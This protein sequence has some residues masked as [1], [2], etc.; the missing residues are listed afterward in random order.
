[1]QKEF[2]IM[3]D[4]CTEYEVDPSHSRKV[5]EWASFRL[6]T[7]TSLAEEVMIVCTRSRRMRIP[8]FNVSGR[9]PISS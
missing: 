4:M 3:C 1:M 8:Q 9:R 7:S 6:Q 5:I 2:P